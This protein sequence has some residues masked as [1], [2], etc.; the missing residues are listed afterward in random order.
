MPIS[1]ALLVAC[2]TVLSWLAFLIAGLLVALIVV[3]MLRAGDAHK[4]TLAMGALVAAGGGLAC[5]F[6]ARWVET[7]F[8]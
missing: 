3:E 8:R 1:R 5:R 4:G 6:A 2:L 7:T